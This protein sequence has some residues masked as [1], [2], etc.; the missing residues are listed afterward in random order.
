MFVK[1]LK[2]NVKRSANIDLAQKTIIVGKNA[3]G[4][5]GII[6]S[7]ELLLTGRCNEVGALPAEIVSLSPV[8]H[9]E[10]VG[11]TSDGVA[12]SFA[13]EGTVSS[14]RKPNWSCGSAIG[15]VV[16]EEISDLLRGDPKRIRQSLL[17]LVGTDLN[18]SDI[19]DHIPSSMMPVWQSLWSEANVDGIDGLIAVGK[20]AKSKYRD[21]KKLLDVV[22]G[23]RPGRP[24]E[25]Q[26]QDLK[27]QI[28][29]AEAVL[30]PNDNRVQFLESVVAL[31]KFS[32]PQEMCAVCMA[33]DF[34]VEDLEHAIGID[35]QEIAELQQNSLGAEDHLLRLKSE[36][37]K[38]YGAAYA[39]RD[40]DQR[41]ERLS[42]ETR[43]I[44]V[45]SSISKIIDKYVAETLPAVISTFTN[46]I[47]NILGERFVLE[48]FDG[49]KPV[50]RFGVQRGDRVVYW[51][52]LSGAERARFTSAV[53]S[54]WAATSEFP[55][56]LVVVDDVWLDDGS[57]SALCKLFDRAIDTG[58]P[59]QVIICV[60]S[61]QLEVPGWKTI[62][63]G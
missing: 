8:G 22:L 39:V 47:S 34:A 13:I 54:A 32:I 57:I 18:V 3:A 33:D 48:L 42:A 20:L 61:T 4:K 58:G 35:E 51:K 28:Q 12:H 10:I 63:L 38:F 30:K 37:Q 16:S 49:D 41:R 23:D 25:A 53:A 55:V 31:R 36:L 56:K 11:T 21:A 52:T 60:V 29:K 17:K 27:D 6:A 19:E 14:A 50:C 15:V 45:Y 62:R 5:S 44:E 7:L 59:T 43:N 26:I 40:Y 24:T 46:R 9:L 1:R 2:S